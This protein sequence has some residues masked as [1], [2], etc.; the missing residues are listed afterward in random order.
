[1]YSKNIANK[2]KMQVFY[3]VLADRKYQKLVPTWETVCAMEMFV[4]TLKPFSAV[5]DSMS[6]EK[7]VGICSLLPLLEK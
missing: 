7:T 2:L 5:T 1:M 6:M 4:E 3:I